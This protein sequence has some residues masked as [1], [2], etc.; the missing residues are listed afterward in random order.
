MP[1]KLNNSRGQCALACL[2]VFALATEVG[3]NPSPQYSLAVQGVE[4]QRRGDNTYDHLWLVKLIGSGF[5]PVVYSSKPEMV[6][7]VLARLGPSNCIRALTLYGHGKP[8]A[9]TLG[10]GQGDVWLGSTYIYLSDKDNESI[11]D[12]RAPM[13]LLK[14]RFCPDAVVTLMGCHTGA[15]AA[16]ATTVFELARFWGVTVRAPVNL[17]FGGMEY[18]GP[19]QKATPDMT[20][21]PPPM[22]PSD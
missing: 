15:G 1:L 13:E 16:G 6:E 5:D 21:P 22:Y 19:W 20:Q 10:K 7:K 4:R 17:V 18:Q 3:S 12:W 14:Q 11:N 8:G 2:I 9:L